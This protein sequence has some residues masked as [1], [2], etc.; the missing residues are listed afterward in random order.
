MDIKVGVI[1]YGYWGPNLVRNLMETEGAVVVSCADLR[2]DRR[3]LLQSRYPTVKAIDD[4]H[5]ILGD[6]N[7]DAVV[8]VTPVSTHHALA[9]RA[10]EQGKHVLVTKPFTR[11]AADAEELIALAEQ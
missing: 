5:A 9:K 11:T 2:P 10:L 8:I 3:A 7:I 6:A 1:G 4:A